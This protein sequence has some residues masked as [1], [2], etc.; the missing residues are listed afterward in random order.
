MSHNGHDMHSRTRPTCLNSPQRL[1]PNPG[2]QRIAAA[3]SREDAH[4]VCSDVH[5]HLDR[6]LRVQDA[7]NTVGDEER[8]C[9]SDVSAAGPTHAG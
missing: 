9:L 6:L 3:S 8:W 2:T 5:S 4:G 1:P 7:M